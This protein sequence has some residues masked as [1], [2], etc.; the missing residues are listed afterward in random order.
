MGRRTYKNHSARRRSS[1]SE[2]RRTPVFEPH[3][4]I[5]V[6]LLNLRTL[7]AQD[8]TVARVEAQIIA[9]SFKPRDAFE[10]AKPLVREL[11]RQ[12]GSAA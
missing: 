11:A 12:A 2:R 9:G 1:R 8:Q 10:R 5:I 6:R 4:R 7:E 3:G